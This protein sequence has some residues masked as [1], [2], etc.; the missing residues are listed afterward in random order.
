MNSE[1][2]D[3]ERR[4]AAVA[5]RLARTKLY[6][7]WIS[8]DSAVPEVHEKM[9]G[10]PGVVRGIEKALPV[11]HEHGIYPS[12][13]LG[14]NWNTG[15]VF[16]GRFAN[17][18]AWYWHFRWS[19]PEFYRFV[20]GLGFTIVNACYPMSAEMHTGPESAV[21]KATSADDVVR[22][23][24]T[25]KQAVFQALFDS[26]P[27]FRSR[28]RIFTP[29][30]ALRALIRQYE[31]DPRAAYPCRGGR[32]FFF[33]D[34]KGGDTFPCGYRGDENLGKLWDLDLAR[35]NDG[36]CRK[37][38]WE[39]FRDPSELFGPIGDLMTRPGRLVSKIIHD[40]ELLRL[41]CKDLRYFRACDFF[42]GRKPPD[43]RKLARFG[44][45]QRNYSDQT[46][47]IPT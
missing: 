26:I 24:T 46:P 4:A 33:V 22:F 36:D 34:A 18:G 11:F 44:S 20:E 1:S 31:G 27:E 5:E 15:G 17:A 12:A 32:E 2:P 19:F 28:L 47:K 23:S 41:W 9:R 42:S 25:E 3:F 10:L 8:V 37:C 38:D 35:R 40:R 45:P 6:T 39:C 21:Y 43:R 30:S 7:F 14:I 29:R 16:D 13:N